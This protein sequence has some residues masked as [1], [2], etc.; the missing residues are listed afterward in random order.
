ME[1]DELLKMNFEDFCRFNNIIISFSDILP[2]KLK[3]M[4]VHTTEYY[5]IVINSKQAINIQKE[6]LLHELA[7]VL[8][9]HFAH[10]CNLTAEECDKEVEKLLDKFKFEIGTCFDLSMF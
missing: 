1:V 6:A 2:N 9:N 4:C 5:E 7:H 10:D 8:K 3:G